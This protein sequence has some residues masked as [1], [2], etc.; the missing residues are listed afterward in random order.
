MEEGMCS[1]PHCLEEQGH[2]LLQDVGDPVTDHECQN[3]LMTR[4]L[5][6]MQ[7]QMRAAPGNLVSNKLLNAMAQPPF[8]EFA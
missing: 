5:L 7:S 8:Q 3:W 2:G 6:R 4:L 1:V